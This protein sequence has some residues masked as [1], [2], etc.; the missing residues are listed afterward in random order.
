M[1]PNV[2]VT[3][4]SRGNYEQ[5]A[6]PAYEF[7]PYTI[8]EPPA[9]PP[10]SAQADTGQPAPPPP[11]RSQPWSRRK[12]ICVVSII[13]IVKVLIIVTSVLIWYFVT[14]SLLFPSPPTCQ[15]SCS[16]SSNCITSNQICNGVTD[17]PYGDD[18]QNCGKECPLMA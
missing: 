18:E 2:S 14:A 17:C 12:K 1:E 13:V 8:P 15:M 11:R 3:Q 10:Y 9:P 16:F 6:S 5:P 7:L 4:P